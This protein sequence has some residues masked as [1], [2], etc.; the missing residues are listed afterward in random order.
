MLEVHKKMDG[1]NCLS[2][3]RVLFQTIK[4]FQNRGVSNFFTK[5]GGKINRTR[6]DFSMF[7]FYSHNLYKCILLLLI[8]LEGVDCLQ[9]VGHFLAAFPKKV[10]LGIPFL[11]PNSTLGSFGAITQV[12]IC[13]IALWKLVLALF[14]FQVIV[15]LSLGEA[16]LVSNT[17][18]SF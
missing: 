9:E 17:R 6:N 4:R 10:K 8:V 15:R 3:F 13:N 1:V 11:I 7:C 2:D 14:F 18:N 12:R 5:T 16:F